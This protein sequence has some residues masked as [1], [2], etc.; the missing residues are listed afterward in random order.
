MSNWRNF[1]R[2]RRGNIGLLAAACF[3]VSLGCTALAIDLGKVF[4]DRRKLQ[5]ATDLAAMVA[6]ADLGNATAAATATAKRNK[7]AANAV[8]SVEPGLY[9]ASSALAPSK[10]FSPSSLSTANAVRV[11]FKT[12]S[13]LSFGKFLVGSDHFEIQTTA[14]ATT[15]GLAAFS[16]GSRL[17]SLNGGLLNDLLQGMLGTSLSLSAMD[18]QALLD[19]RV[20]AFDFL[21]ALAAQVDITGVTYDELLSSNMK[22]ADVLKALHATQQSTNGN[23]AGTAALAAMSQAMLGSQIQIAPSALIDTGPY[24]G[25]P[26]AQKPKAGVGLSAFDVVF[27]TGQLAN[28]TNQISA[29]AGLSLPGVVSATLAATIGERPQ[30]KSWITVGTQGAS[31]HTAQTR[32]LLTVQLA[33]IGG[34]ASVNLPVYVEVASGTAQLKQIACG[35]PDVQTSTVKLAVT[36]GIVDAWIGQITP[37]ELANFTSAPNPPPATLVTL[38]GAKVTGRAHAAI[39]NPGA[40]EVVFDYSDISAHKKKTVNT[41]SFAGSLTSTLLGDLQLTVTALGFGLPVPGL[42]ASVANIASGATASIDQLLATSLAALG[43]GV[44]QADVWVSGIRCDGAVLV[45]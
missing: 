23:N 37:A 9:V 3:G 31:V 18:Y 6:A 12:K 41:T 10:R 20:D 25:L 32:I 33:G 43:V 5:S 39:A 19:A 38:P 40:T 27:A 14:T 45:N 2:D 13:P 34:I 35:Y 8:V 4:A 16:I 15:T 36:P 29:N 21:G 11:T 22:A 28:G 17:A 24:G 42:G 44:G 1:L 7:Y 30:G 26:V